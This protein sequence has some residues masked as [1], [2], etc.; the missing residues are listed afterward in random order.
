[1][2]LFIRSGHVKTEM[3]REH[4]VTRKPATEVMHPQAK[5]KTLKRAAHHQKLGRDKEGLRPYRS[6]RKCGTAG[7]LILDF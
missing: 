7:T 1:M 5:P 4:H 6:Q 2:D 3:Q